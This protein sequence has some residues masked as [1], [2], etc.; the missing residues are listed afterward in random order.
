MT[1]F[2][3]RLLARRII[4]VARMATEMHL[5]ADAASVAAKTHDRRMD[6]AGGTGVRVTD[7]KAIVGK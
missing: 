5:R 3:G 2:N 7:D 4:E 6:A 1:D